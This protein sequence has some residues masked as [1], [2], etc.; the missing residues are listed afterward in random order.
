MMVY[1]CNPSYSRGEDQEELFKGKPGKKLAR[2][3]LNKQAK[4]IP[5]I[6]AMGEA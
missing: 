3:H 5:V 6:P 1:S 4:Y 2:P